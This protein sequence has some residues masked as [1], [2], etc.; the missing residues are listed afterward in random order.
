MEE[1]ERLANRPATEKTQYQAVF[2]GLRRRVK[3]TMISLA[4]FTCPLPRE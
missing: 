2:E 4:F 3:L 1:P